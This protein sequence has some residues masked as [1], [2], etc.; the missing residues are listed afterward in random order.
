LLDLLIAQCADLETLLS[1]ARRSLAAAEA[2]DFAEVL[3]VVEER[4]TLGERLE[5]YHRQIAE[6]RL[7]LG[8]A[9][10]PA[11]QG[12]VARRA[13]MLASEVLTTD[14][15]SRP[16]LVAARGRL[17]GECLRVDRTKRGLSAYLRDGRKSAL[18]CDS[19]A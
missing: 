1:L 9:A 4:A 13:A 11:I 3:R 8:D 18:V 17:A 6:M 12:A 16:L 7:R 19:L 15:R 5:T 14:A 2:S 10:E